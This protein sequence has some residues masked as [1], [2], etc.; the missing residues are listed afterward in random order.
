[1]YTACQNQGLAQIH[2]RWSDLPRLT[3]RRHLLWLIPVYVFSGFVMT[4]FQATDQ[5]AYVDSLGRL[6]FITAMAAFA[7]FALKIL[8]AVDVKSAASK[9]DARSRAR[10][11][12]ARSDRREGRG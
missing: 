6:M 4:T 9:E 8:P 10:R 7:V 11:P 5:T 1:M 3:L 2:F 12:G